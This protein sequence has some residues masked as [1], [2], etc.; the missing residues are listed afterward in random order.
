MPSNLWKV[1]ARPAM[2]ALLS[3]FTTTDRWH[4]EVRC[5]PLD[6]DHI[7]E[8]HFATM[9]TREDWVKETISDPLAVYRDAKHPTRRVFF[10]HYY[11]PDFDWQH[12]AFLRVIVEY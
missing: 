6:W 12:Y 10:R 7:M 8:G 3:P 2:T 9:A 1:T 11:I 5:R 4:N